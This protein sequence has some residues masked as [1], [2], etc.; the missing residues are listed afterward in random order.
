MCYGQ[1]SPISPTYAA[2]QTA[3][4]VPVFRFALL[5][6]FPEKNAFFTGGAGHM[7]PVALPVGFCNSLVI[8]VL[9]GGLTFSG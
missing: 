5:A 4:A 8:N 3:F 1:S 6:F 9:G 7:L 2:T